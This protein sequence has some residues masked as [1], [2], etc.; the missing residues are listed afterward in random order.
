MSG[1]V[2]NVN[3]L[4]AGTVSTLLSQTCPE[5]LLKRAQECPDAIAFRDKH[6][7]IYVGHSWRE[8]LDVVEEVSLGL[9]EIG[10][11]KGDRVAVM[12]DPCPEWAY[13]DMAIMALGGITVGVYPTNSPNEIEYIV[14]DSGSKIFIAE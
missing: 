7:G 12:G 8:Y 9:R 14:N 3:V 2:P 10:A 4:D 1:T 11:A 5:L 13:S 6:L